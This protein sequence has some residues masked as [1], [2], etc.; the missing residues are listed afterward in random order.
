MST[1]SSTGGDARPIA[2]VHGSAL[3]STEPLMLMAGVMSVGRLV[4][5]FRDL[6][7]RARCHRQVASLHHHSLYDAARRYTFASEN[8]A[9]KNASA[10]STVTLGAHGI[11]APQ[12]SFHVGCGD[13]VQGAT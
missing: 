13:I 4:R 12:D 7:V 2:Q 8:P 3:V 5:H 10:A 11:D 6:V 9:S 1:S